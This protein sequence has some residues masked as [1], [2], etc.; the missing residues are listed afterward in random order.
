MPYGLLNADASF[1][2][3]MDKVLG[4]YLGSFVRVFM[5]DFCVFSDRWI[6]KHKL[7]EVFKRIDDDG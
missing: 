7:E 4:P 5:D 1:Q 3:W 6:H 2:S